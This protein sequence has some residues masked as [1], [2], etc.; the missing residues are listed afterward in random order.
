MDD[1]DAPPFDQQRQLEGSTCQTAQAVPVARRGER[2]GNASRAGPIGER[3]SAGR[4]E[5]GGKALRVKVPNQVDED[6]AA[7]ADLGGVR[8]IQ[9][10]T[11]RHFWKIGRA[12]V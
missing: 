2:A 9:N 6:L 12:H 5:M 3:S 7:T 8:D 4:Y 1:G 11:R 10:D